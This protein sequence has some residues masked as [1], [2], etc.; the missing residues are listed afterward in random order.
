MHG[1]WGR[2][3]RT[4][5]FWWVGKVYGEPCQCSFRGKGV[6]YTLLIRFLFH[7]LTSGISRGSGCIRFHCGTNDCME[8]ICRLSS[9]D[10]HCYRNLKTKTS[11]VDGRL[12]LVSLHRQWVLVKSRNKWRLLTCNARSR[13]DFVATKSVGMWSRLYSCWCYTLVDVH[14]RYWREE[15]TRR[16]L[17]RENEF[18]SLESCT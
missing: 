15:V 13:S 9:F 16:L 10:A 1:P 3:F 12:N 11:A 7:Q 8:D 6:V 18:V 5:I 4:G 17:M 14:D 2:E